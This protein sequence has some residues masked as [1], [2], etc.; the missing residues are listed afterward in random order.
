MTASRRNRA[1][2]D[3]AVRC[4]RVHA[5]HRGADN[6]WGL[7]TCGLVALWALVTMIPVM[8]GNWRLKAGFVAVSFAAAF[9]ALWPTLR[10]RHERQAQVPL[11]LQGPHS[12]R[13]RP[14]GSTSGA[15]CGSSTRSRSRRR[16]ATSATTSPTTC[17]QEL[18]TIYQMHT[19]E[20]LVTRDEIAKLEDKVHVSN[21]KEEPQIV[22]VTFKDPADI[23]KLDDRYQK[24]FATELIQQRGPGA[25]VI[26]Y[27]IRT[28][29]ET[30]IRDKA[31]SQ[32]KD[33][34]N[35]RVDE[36]GLRE[37]SVTTRDEDII[38]EVPGENKAAFEEIK[39]IIR[40]TARLEFKMVD[41][42]GQ[43]DFF[44]K[45]KEADNCK[46]GDANCL[47]PSQGFAIFEAGHEPDGVPG[48]HHA[49]R[50]RSFTFSV[51]KKRRSSNATSD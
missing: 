20:G 28:E 45:Y 3:R 6:F 46:A 7:I 50:R 38:I 15:A 8:D 40:R 35:K 43:R 22:R 11:V 36:L 27:K 17:A 9:V 30:S 34:I 48:A 13:H 29:V 31:V 16:S 4:G 10:G 21:P 41:V 42:V 49:S 44:S 18:A 23:N 25:N 47:P 51:R 2:F 32:A 19:G 1:H 12:L 33:T 39:D 37:A 26:T 5:F 24:R 14:G